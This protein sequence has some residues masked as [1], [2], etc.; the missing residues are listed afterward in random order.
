MSL[1]SLRDWCIPYGFRLRQKALPSIFD[2]FINVL[3]VR[4]LGCTNSLFFLTLTTIGYNSNFRNN[5]EF[6][7][8][9]VRTI[10]HGSETIRYRGVFS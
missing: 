5:N 8:P 3:V 4:T 2:G 7:Q 6:L 10:S 1:N 9:S